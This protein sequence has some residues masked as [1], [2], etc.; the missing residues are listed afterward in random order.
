MPRRSSGLRLMSSKLL[1][2]R[3]R[4][5]S[6]PDHR[7]TATV[8]TRRPG[9]SCARERTKAVVSK[10]R[11]GRVAKSAHLDSMTASSGSETPPPAAAAEAGAAGAASAAGASGLGGQQKKKLGQRALSRSS[12]RPWWIPPLA[13]PFTARRMLP[14]TLPLYPRTRQGPLGRGARSSLGG[15]C[16]GGGSH[17]E[18][19]CVL[20]WLELEG[21][22]RTSGSWEGVWV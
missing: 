11:G 3:A 21:R 1:H 12:W 7:S 22:V 14:D 19:R 5:S 18:L 9:P 16:V 10:F 4:I 20:C 17:D 15:R 2:R 8:R 6:S 13:L